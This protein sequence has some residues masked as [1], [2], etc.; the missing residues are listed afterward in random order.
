MVSIIVPVY[1][2]EKYLHRCIDSVLNQTYRELELLL[3][4]DGSTDS[5]G[6]ICDE[7]ARRDERIRIIHK[8]NT[9]VSDTRNTA[10][11]I[12]KGDYILFL[13]SDDY[14]TIDFAIEKLLT[15]AIKNDLDIIRGEYKSVDSLGKDFF[16]RDIERDKLHYMEKILDSSIFLDKILL[17]E[18]F[19]PL[20]LIK[21]SVLCDVRFNVKRVFLEDIEFFLCLLLKPVKCMYIPLRFYAYRKHEQ[22][23]SNNFS[24]E[25]LRDAFDMSRL[26]FHLSDKAL[27]KKMRSS[28]IK[29]GIDYYRLT[30]QTMAVNDKYYVNRQTLC[31]ELN[32]RALGKDVARYFFFLIRNG[33]FECFLCSL[34]MVEYYRIK[35]YI[36][37]R[38]L[39]IK[40]R[41]Q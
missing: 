20:C 8:I 39:L 38:Y 36:R 14:L 18:F 11:D 31:E 24:V 5:S 21:T 25:R 28:F 30:L 26:Y 16:I 34:S 41:K 12:A 2:T 10:L 13:D 40:K 37:N 23:A 19:L 9:G 1:N 27:N 32:L 29:R 17:R 33:R 15:E 35:N 7:Y 4:D 3:I 22:S 6:A